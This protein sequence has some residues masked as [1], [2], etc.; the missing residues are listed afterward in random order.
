MYGS[1]DDAVLTE[2]FGLDS[3]YSE[4]ADKLR[5]RLVD[6]EVKALAGTA[7]EQEVRQYKELRE[8]LTSSLTARVDEVAA[9]LR[10]HDQD[11]SS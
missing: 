1:G 5:A 3:P 4:R 7:D 11:L 8:K 10:T 6:L 2:L 9:R